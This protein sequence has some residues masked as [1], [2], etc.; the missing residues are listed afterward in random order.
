MPFVGLLTH[1]LQFWVTAALC[2]PGETPVTDFRHKSATGIYS[3]G[4]VQD[5]NLIILFSGIGSSPKPPRSA[6]QLSNSIIDVFS[7][8][9]NS[10]NI[11]RG[12]KKDSQ[13][14]KAAY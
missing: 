1:A 11:R 10:K 6:I 12:S 14:S 8:G 3:G 13:T 9:V 2:L 5:S 7:I 4:T